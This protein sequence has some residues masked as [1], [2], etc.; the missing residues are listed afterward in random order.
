MAHD[1]AYCL[2]SSHSRRTVVNLTPFAYT[3]RRYLPAY[4]GME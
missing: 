1:A 2:L 3:D 4:P